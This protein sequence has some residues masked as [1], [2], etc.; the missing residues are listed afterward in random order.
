[1][2]YLKHFLLISS[3]GVSSKIWAQDAN[4][5]LTFKNSFDSTVVENIE[6]I[7]IGRNNIQLKSDAN[8]YMSAYLQPSKKHN[9]RLEGLGYEHE[10]IN[11]TLAPNQTLDTTILLTA[12]FEMLEGAE[13]RDEQY[14]NETGTIKIDHEKAFINPGPNSGIEGLLKIFTGD[15]NELSSQYKVRGG[16]FDENLVYVNDF[17]I[18][19]PFLVR[20]GQQE[21]LS[22]VNAD[23]VKNVNFSVGGFQAKYGDKMSSVLDV[24]YKRPKEFGGSVMASLLGANLHLEG[25]TKDNKVAYLFSARQKT[26]Q[27]LLRSQPVKGQYN[28]SF[29]DVQGMIN[30]RLAAGWEMEVLGNYARNRFSYQPESR[31]SAFGYFNNMMRL[32]MAYQGQEI[33]QFDTRFLGWSLQYK[34]TSTTKLKILASAFQT[35]ES[36]AYDIRGL[37]DLYTVESDLGSSSFAQNK[38]HLGSGEMHDFARNRLTAN[39]Y[40]VGHRGSHTNNTHAIQWGIDATLVKVDDYLLEWQKRDSAGYAQPY[41]SNAIHFY[42][43]VAAQNKLDYARLAAF[44]QDN[45]AFGANKNVIL[46]I[47]VRANY[48]T[49]NEELLI[50][51]RMQLSYKPMRNENII[52]KISSGWY[53]QQPFYR[54]MR[55]DLGILNTNLKAQKSYQ[56]AGGFDWNFKM[57]GDRPFK[58]TGEMYYK[59]LWDLV[60]YE[61]D[62]VRIRYNADNNA[63]GYAY[64]GELRLFGE[65]VKDAES[66]VS[67]GLMKT[68][69]R[70]FDHQSQ[71]WSEYIDRPTDQRFTLGMFFSDYLPGNKN[72]KVFLNMM[73]ASGLPYGPRTEN[74]IPKYQMRIPAYKRVDIGFATLLL[75]GSIKGKYDGTIFKGVESMWFSLEVFNLLGI[76]NT[77]SYEWIQDFSNDVMYAVPNRLTSRLLN[78]KLAIRF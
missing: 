55:N 31:S 8:G 50:S 9:F 29:T 74:M 17:E 20:S 62:N 64:G 35:N 40:T 18:Q 69:N 72:F 57:L 70:I 34:P 38:Y 68:Q 77:L 60:P 7:G 75:D 24:T 66:W 43:S 2:K 33:D 1:M 27:Y 46:N 19:R 59:N 30:W 51:P 10:Y 6:L 78:A 71:T 49:S 52:W 39:I 13:V 48:Q 25:A 23:L 32:E 56:A 65:L 5:K 3:L 16:N 15:H 42:K 22:F 53:Q 58:L 47:G 63:K 4:F 54:E 76:Q 44:I 21:G 12:F 37:Y 28:P 14:R 41:D 36:E 26:N 45:I 61:Y 11:I 67:L 73:F